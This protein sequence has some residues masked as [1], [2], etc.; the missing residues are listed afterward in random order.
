MLYLVKQ[1][2]TN[3]MHSLRTLSFTGFLIL[4]LL[5]SGCDPS[6]PSENL[7]NTSLAE[8]LQIKRDFLQDKNTQYLRSLQDSEDL[9]DP[10]AI[11]TPYPVMITEN[12]QTVAPPCEVVVRIPT[13]PLERESIEKYL[14]QEGLIKIDSCCNMELWKRPDCQEQNSPINDEL[15]SNGSDLSSGVG[16]VGYNRYVFGY[17]TPTGGT[18]TTKLDTTSSLIANP[19]MVAVLDTGVDGIHD[20]LLAY[21]YTPELTI[22]CQNDTVT[23]NYIDHKAKPLDDNGHGTHVSGIITHNLTQKDITNF[24]IINYKTHDEN[25]IATL[26]D[27]ICAMYQAKAD[28]I[29]VINASWGF[30]GESAIFNTALDSLNKDSIIMVN[31]AGNDAKDID[32]LQFHPTIMALNNP[33]LLSVGAYGLSGNINSNPQFFIT[34][35]TNWSS[36]YIDFGAFGDKV[37][38]TWPGNDYSC[39]DGTSMA[40]PAVTAKV[41]ELLLQG[42]SRNSIK[43]NIPT[44]SNSNFLTKFKN[45]KLLTN[46]GYS[47]MQQCSEGKVPGPYKPPVVLD[48]IVLGDPRS[49]NQGR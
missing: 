2:K 1:T 24:K 41:V 47:W 17:T 21:L 22:G 19:I 3:S 14:A 35:F 8:T 5:N 39:L 28:S 45:G 37:K 34:D 11:S 26:F 10:D 48:S 49:N 9:I 12:C 13:D 7:C 43:A 31:S 33:L 25:G 40:A 15:T 18:P 36:K 42:V 32:S 27:I 4:C 44:V 6:N 38:S 23:R 20:S 30:Y 16:G 29:D 46:Y